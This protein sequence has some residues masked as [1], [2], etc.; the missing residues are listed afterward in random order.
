MIEFLGHELLEVFSFQQ[1]FEKSNDLLKISDK[2]PK[3]Q[4]NLQNFSDFWKLARL[5][6]NQRKVTKVLQ[7]VLDF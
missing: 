1:K 4:N 5:N 7:F 2:I 3:V 6:Q